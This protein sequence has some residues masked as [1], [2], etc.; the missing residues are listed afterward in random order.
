MC[1]YIHMSNIT[2]LG[3]GYTLIKNDFVRKLIWIL[4]KQKFVLRGKL[5]I[6][7]IKSKIKPNKVF[8][9]PL[10]KC[11]INTLEWDGVVFVIFFGVRN[12]RR[13]I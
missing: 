1:L 10:L 9:Y 4:K 8:I 5:S 2:H 11:T 13:K 6:C 3:L 12:E 7:T